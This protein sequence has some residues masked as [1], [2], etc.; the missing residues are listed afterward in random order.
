[1]CG[2]RIDGLRQIAT[3]PSIGYENRSSSGQHIAHRR[4]M[5]ELLCDQLARLVSVFD[6]LRG[7]RLRRV[8]EARDQRLG[9]AAG[10]A[11][12]LSSNIRPDAWGSA[13]GNL[14]SFIDA[15]TSSALEAGANGG[16]AILHDATQG[17]DT[18]STLEWGDEELLSD[19]EDLGA[20]ER[21]QLQIENEALVTEMEAMV[22]QARAAES[23]MLEISQLSHLFAT[24]VEQQTVEIEMLSHQAE[25]TSGAPQ[26]SCVSQYPLALLW[27]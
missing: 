7:H 18:I 22:E 17:G 10:V 15:S 27:P 26:I 12:A 19:D 16:G 6:E 25:Q 11:G 24:R 2:E 14:P 5:L 1:M 3:Q 21:A 9:A 13:L 4:G 8:A 23:S 20:T